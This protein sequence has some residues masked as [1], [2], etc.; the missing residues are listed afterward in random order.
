MKINLDENLIFRKP[1]MIIFFK[2]FN[3]F[4]DGET[5]INPE[6]DSNI[7]IAVVIKKC[8]AITRFFNSS[9][10]SLNLLKEEFQKRNQKYHALMQSTP[11]R[12]NS[13]LDMLV[14]LYDALDCVNVVLLKIDHN[15]TLLT[16]REMDILPDVIAVLTPFKTATTS[17]S[18]E[19]YATVST[20]IPAVGI[21]LDKITY[22]VQ[23]QTE[24]GK[25]FRILV[26]N[27]IR[28]KL[29]IYETRM[30]V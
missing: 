11:T 6:D 30:Y 14:N 17:L 20:I 7:S 28:Q 21:L 27:L 5:K 1:T 16:K 26:E 2:D 12:W 22:S 29:M 24:A 4:V 8:K 23:V 18:G 19:K 3:D 25:E 9:P 15:V 10:K 13:V